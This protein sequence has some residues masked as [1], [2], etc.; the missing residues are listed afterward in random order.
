MYFPVPAVLKGNFTRFVSEWLMK[1]FHCTTVPG[2][3]KH[4]Y[5]RRTWIGLVCHVFMFVYRYAAQ[6]NVGRYKQPHIIC[7]LLYTRAWRFIFLSV[8]RISTQKTSCGLSNLYFMK[9]T[10]QLCR[11]SSQAHLPRF[12]QAQLQKSV[13][14]INSGWIQFLVESAGS[15]HAIDFSLYRWPV[16]L[17]NCWQTYRFQAYQ[18][19]VPIHY[20]R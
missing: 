10:H 12:C 20:P 9:G 19:K 3:L 11:L 5:L 7:C 14:K 4:W 1:I 16:N 17:L 15:T 2:K 13:E 18:G 6:L 8:Y